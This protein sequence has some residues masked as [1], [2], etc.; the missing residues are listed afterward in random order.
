MKLFNSLPHSIIKLRDDP[1]QLKLARIKLCYPYSF[2]STGEM[3][4]E[5][6]ELSLTASVH[7]RFFASEVK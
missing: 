2:Y 5:N 3:S 7:E 6:D 4:I 1:K